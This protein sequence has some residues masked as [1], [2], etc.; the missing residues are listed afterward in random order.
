MP[1][2]FFSLAL[3]DQVELLNA[4]SARSGHPAPL[5]EKDVWVVGT[6]AC[7]FSSS[8][9][10]RLTFK[11][12]TS[13]S[14]AY[15]VIN[16]FSDDLDL[17]YDIRSLLPE[18][19]TT[20]DGIPPTSS[21]AAKW[22]KAVRSRLPQWIQGR[23]V[24]ILQAA[25]ADSGM[26]A[27]LEI[28]GKDSDSILVKYAPLS[29]GTG[30]V[31]PNV[32]LEFGARSTGEPCEVLPVICDLAPFV[33]EIMFPHAHLRVMK[34][35]RTFWEKATAIHVFCR[36]AKI[37]GSRFARHWHDLLQLAATERIQNSLLDKS[38]LEQVVR[39]KTMFFQEK[40]PTGTAIDYRECLNGQ[41]CLVP[42]GIEREALRDD[43]CNMVQDGIFF[44]EAPEFDV[45]LDKCAHLQEK[46]NSGHTN[47][48]TSLRA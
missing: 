28:I 16:R 7:L 13:L 18:M 10:D 22:T 38:W 3:T 36:H 33:P 44:T 30:N 2:T 17:T 6:L 19:A 41:L 5:L 29:Q 14:K 11:G 32:K 9:A 8:L 25:L 42:D 39:H 12:G 48:E 26:E 40:D 43:Y 4:V 37:R 45:I 31:A 46:I 35:E 27:S 34:M 20:P 24:P 23:V 47:S 21:Q 15:N 1:K